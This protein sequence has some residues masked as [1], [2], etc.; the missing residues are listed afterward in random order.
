V[1]KI[2]ACASGEIAGIDVKHAKP[3]SRQRIGYRYVFIV[4]Q[5]QAYLSLIDAFPNGG[6]WI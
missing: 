3:V 2:Y 1:K 5:D 6:D 4:C